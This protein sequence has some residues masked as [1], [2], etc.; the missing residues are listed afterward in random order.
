LDRL[1][2]VFFLYKNIN[3]HIFVKR[4]K[5]VSSEAQVVVSKQ[6]SEQNDIVSE[7]DCTGTVCSELVDRVLERKEAGELNIDFSLAFA[8]T[9]VCWKRH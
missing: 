3:K 8:F 1:Y 9:Q 2:I 7:I 6:I 5:V 4:H